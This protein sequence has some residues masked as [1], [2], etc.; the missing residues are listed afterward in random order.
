MVISRRQLRVGATTLMKQRDSVCTPGNSAVPIPHV[1]VIVSPAIPPR[2]RGARAPVEL[3]EGD[4]MTWN[5]G[6]VRNG[7]NSGETIDL[8][9]QAP[10]DVRDNAN[11]F[12]GN[13][14][15]YANIADNVL[16]GG[17]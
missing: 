4:V 9:Y 6:Q 16:T 3:T 5:N 8:R 7:T 2:R 12:A 15:I 14:T 1:P 11:G 10:W 17:A 13:D